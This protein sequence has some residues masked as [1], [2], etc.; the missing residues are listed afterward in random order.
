M[1][2]TKHTGIG[3][4]LFAKQRALSGHEAQL[5]RSIA[6]AHCNQSKPAHGDGYHAPKPHHGHCHTHPKPCHTSPPHHHDSC[7]PQGSMKVDK[8]GAVTTPGGYKIEVTGPCAWKITGPDCKETCISGDPHVAEGDGG[9]WDFQRDSTFMLGDGTRINVTTKPAGPNATVTD[10]LEIIAG[11]DRVQLKDVQKGKGAPAKVTHDGFQHANSF[12]GKDVIVMGKQSD[13]W[14]FK[15]R[16]IIGSNNNGQSFKLGKPLPVGGSAHKSVAGPAAPAPQPQ[17]GAA[18]TPAAIAPGEPAPV[19]APQ[20]FAQ[21]LSQLFQGLAQLFSGLAQASNGME[22]GP[23]F[24]LSPQTAPGTEGK[25]IERR[26]KHL[27]Q[28]FDDIGRMMDVFAR[29]GDLSRSIQNL[30]GTFT[31]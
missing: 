5:V 31:A 29:A 12:G 24:N 30:R 13:D 7:H 8:N 27:G 21:Q 3:Q 28:G 18:G 4:G 23:L 19:K 15:G 11:N 9:K 10:G 17:A 20:S 2:S 25:W 14:S 26:E 16:E 1:I 22:K 6:K